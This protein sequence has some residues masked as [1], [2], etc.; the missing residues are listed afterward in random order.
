MI[1]LIYFEIKTRISLSILNIYKIFFRKIFYIT[2]S[3]EG[4]GTGSMAGS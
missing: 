1:F 4:I 3:L 2:F